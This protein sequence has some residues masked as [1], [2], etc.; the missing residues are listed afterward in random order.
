M[1]EK[2]RAIPASCDSVGFAKIRG[3]SRCHGT[4][5]THVQ[6]QRRGLRY[7]SDMTD[8]EST[9]IERHLPPRRRP[10]KVRLRNVVEA[11]LFILSRVASGGLCRRSFRKPKPTAAVIDSQSAPTTQAGG[12]RGFDAGKRVHGRKRPIVTD[13]NGLLLAVHVHPA[14]VQDC[15]GAVPLLKLMR[16]RFPKLGHVFA[17]RIIAAISSS[18]R[19]LVP[20]HGHRDCGATT[21]RQRLPASTAALGGRTHLRLV[22]SM[23]PPRQ[24]LRR[25]R[26]Y[27]GRMAP[28][29]TSEA[30]YQTARQCPK[31]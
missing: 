11:I 25:I 30:S 20:D 22:R 10:R 27:R 2:R 17:E 1:T 13:T 16:C 26:V 31:H 12:P 5:I 8:A 21:R 19:S 4:E 15:H 7:A 6:Y 14:N 24:G 18:V 9:L 29:R 3:R 23:P 28:R